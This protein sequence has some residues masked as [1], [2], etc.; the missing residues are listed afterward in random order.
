METGLKWAQ[1]SIP[2]LIDGARSSEKLTTTGHVRKS[3]GF[4]ILTQ[5]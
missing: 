1:R 5:F 3:V 2:Q 4:I